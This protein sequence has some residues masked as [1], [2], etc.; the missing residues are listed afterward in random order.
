MTVSGFWPPW[1]SPAR[2]VSDYWESGRPLLRLSQAVRPA[3]RPR[4]SQ[5]FIKSSRSQ[6]KPFFI[7]APVLK[8][9]LSAKGRGPRMVQAG[10]GALS[11]PSCAMLKAGLSA[12]GRGPPSGPLAVLGAAPRGPSR[13]SAWAVFFKD[14]NALSTPS[15]AMLK[16]GLSAQGRGPPIV[17][18]AP[19]AQEGKRRSPRRAYIWR[20]PLPPLPLSANIPKLRSD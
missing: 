5:L 7:K 15:C 8:A 12:K 17:P 2:T 6:K 18:Q 4:R 10:R 14:R 1:A 9:G 19:W 3:R 20:C 13:V 11:T 16:V